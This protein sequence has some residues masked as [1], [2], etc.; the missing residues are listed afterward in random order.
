MNEQRFTCTQCGKCCYGWLPL[1]RDEA[2]THASLYPL[3]MAWTPVHPSSKNFALAERLGLP[4][5]LPNRKRIALLIG[6]IAYIPPAFPCPALSPDNLCRIHEAK[7]LRCRTMPFYP[8]REEADQCDLLV[9]RKGW[10]CDTSAQAELVYLNRSI[11]DRTDFDR[12]LAQAQSEAPALRAYAQKTLEQVP[13]MAA[14]IIKAAQSPS[15]GRVVMNF[16]G[17]LRRDKTQDLI[18]FAKKQRPVLSFYSEQTK[19]KPELAAYYRYYSQTEE[20]LAWFE[21][22]GSGS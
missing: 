22:R 9:P 11:C 19:T 7:P 10:M 8:F 18:D 2:F 1:T 21:K 13:A 14:R 16:S 3:A 5:Q 6:A 12:E 17:F 20:E 4:F 15:G